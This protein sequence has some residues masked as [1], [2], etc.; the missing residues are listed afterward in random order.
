MIILYIFLGIIGFLLILLA[1]MLFIPLKIYMK[2][3]YWDKA[4]AGQM[5]T[6]WI[7]YFM[8]ARLRITDKEY[9]R[10]LIWFFGIPIPLK[11]KISDKT[12]K[13]AKTSDK[14]KIEQI[15]NEPV[16]ISEKEDAQ[17]HNPDLKEKISNLLKA[18]DRV[19][20]FW[21]RYKEYFKKLYVS[22]ITFS[23]DFIDTELGLKD[24]SQ[25]GM[26]AGIVYSTLALRPLDNIKVSWDYAKPKFNIKTGIKMSM[27]LCGILCTL[28]KLFLRFKKDKKN[29]LQ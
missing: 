2:G 23:I 18:K 6:Y 21:D 10:I 19:L 15:E 13:K 17:K 5:D 29:E 14:S 7:K 11:F 4:P 16:R 12:E 25:T 28:L 20:A 9:V 26:I 24:P 27:N 8:G 1:I 3:T 22:Y